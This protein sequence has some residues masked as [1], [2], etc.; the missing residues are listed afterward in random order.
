MTTSVINS[1][2]CFRVVDTCKLISNYQQVYKYVHQPLSVTSF[3]LNRFALNAHNL[4]Q[5]IYCILSMF[6]YQLLTFI[7]KVQMV[8]VKSF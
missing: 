7:M 5:N 3:V 6:R 4:L 2:R 8:N 1:N